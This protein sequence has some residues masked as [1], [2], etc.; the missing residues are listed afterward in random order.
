[1]LSDG[2]VY[3]NLGLETAWKQ[4]STIL[5]SGGGGKMEAQAELRGDWLRY[6]RR[7]LDVVDNQVRVLRKRQLINS[8]K[9]KTPGGAYW[10]IGT[11]IDDDAF[12]GALPSP[13]AN[14]MHLA[15]VATRLKTMSAS[16]QERPTNWGY[17]VCNA[18]LHKHVDD[19]LSPGRF[20]YPSAE[21]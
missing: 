19:T 13:H 15:E 6:T 10:G 5:V 4:Y 18:A 14:T 12:P 21:V 2:G 1:M 11:N 7:G 8:L 16:L 9:S 20:P 17:A 3:D